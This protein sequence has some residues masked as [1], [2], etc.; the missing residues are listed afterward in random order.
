MKV[1]LDENLGKR[2]ADLLRDAGWDVETVLS[3]NLCTATDATLASV[4]QAEGRVLI[5][6]D[7]DFANTLLFK[8][9]LH[10]GL[11]VLRLR[12]PLLPE[13]LEGAL[14]RVRDLAEARSPV[15]QLWVVD[16]HRIREHIESQDP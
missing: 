16:D 2:G 15:G 3:E 9:S 11:V 1:K 12:S 13:A 14:R 4:C 10:A 7:L 5:S 6:L 8:P